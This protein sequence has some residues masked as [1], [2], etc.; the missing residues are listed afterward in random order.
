[1][2]QR[3]IVATGLGAVTSIGLNVPDF[4]QSILDR[5][6]GIGQLGFDT[7]QFTTTIGGGVDQFDPT[8]YISSREAR[9]LDRFV[10][11]ALV[12]GDEAIADAGLSDS[13]PD[14]TRVG[15]IL[16]TG[17][18][19]IY[20][21][22]TQHV[23][24]LEKGPG[25]VN[26]FM[27]PK[28]MAN[29]CS[30]QLAIRHGFNGPNHV[31]SAACASGNVAIAE[32]I[33]LIRM[34]EADVVISGGTEA[35][36]TPLGVAGFCQARAL[37]K[38]NDDPQHAS[39]PFDTDRDGFVMGE[40]AGMVVLEELEH[41]RKRGA[42]IYAELVGYGLTCDAHDI[43]APE[44]EGRGA[45]RAMAMALDDARVNPGEVTYINTHGTS[46][47]LG[48]VAE[49][50][51]I[52]RT[53]GEH[54]PDIL[55]NST[56]SY[57]G[58]LLGASG[59]AEMVACILQIHHGVIHPTLNLDNQDPECNINCVTGDPVETSIGVAITNSFGFGGHNACVVMKPFED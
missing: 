40:G 53:F 24:L 43:V 2:S 42:T 48:D 27:I 26:P 39:R 9:H 6:S 49:A 34:G 44:P 8:A 14:P 55:C 20:E 4:W 35:A 50:K 16:G 12:A 25:R 7:S 32:A 45:G 59:G 22:E 5:R 15:V 30:G 56:K 31:V 13:T 51:A 11:F 57:I 54:T 37:S 29:A 17:I 10:Q 28:L 1:M 33:Q 52:N 23:R 47:P 41:A 19:G 46:T 36:L 58:H 38:R 21:I 3:R 18:G